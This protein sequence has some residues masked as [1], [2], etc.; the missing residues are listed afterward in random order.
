MEPPTLDGYRE[1]LREQ[2]IDL[3]DIERRQLRE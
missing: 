1:V 2:G 3:R